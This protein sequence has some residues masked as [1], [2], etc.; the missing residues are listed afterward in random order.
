MFGG[1]TGSEY[2]NQALLISPSDNT[3]TRGK[4]E[5][6]R[7]FGL[8]TGRS[9]HSLTFTGDNIYLL[10]GWNSVKW[11]NENTDYSQLWS[12][13]STWNWSL[14]EIFGHQPQA[15]RGHSTNYFK[16]NNVLVVFGGMYGYSKLLN[17]LYFFYLN[18]MEWKKAERN[19]MWPKQRAW[20][21]ASTVGR[22]LYVFGGLLEGR[23]VTS[24]L[25]KFE[26]DTVIWTEITLEN[27]PCPRYG[28]VAV[29][30]EDFVFIFGGY[31]QN[32][33]PLNDSYV[34]DTDQKYS[35]FTY[36]VETEAVINKELEKM[37]IRPPP[38]PKELERS[39]FYKPSPE[40][41]PR[42]FK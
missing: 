14:C 12:L 7:S 8:P 32:E 10:G 41:N 30:A 35:E 1:W 5:M 39:R 11:N 34:L 38:I 40:F 19:E 25:L 4:E 27:S 20:H 22:A 31:S 29:L 17:S 42:H 21:T 15:R 28:H 33:I 26:L 36:A 2:S 6:S 18:T 9:C 16:G 3:A 23:Q 37:W 24:Q 13:D